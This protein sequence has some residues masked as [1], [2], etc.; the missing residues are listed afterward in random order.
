MSLDAI[1]RE[2]HKNAAEHGFWDGERDP[3]DLDIAEVRRIVAEKIA[4]IHSEASE[5]LEDVRMVAGAEELSRCRISPTGKPVGFASELADIV[6]RVA[7]LA[8]WLRVDLEAEIALKMQHNA[9][10]PRKHGKAF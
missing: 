8:G 4:L 3:N 1:V 9:G 2:A 5:A 6:I 7:D 10:R